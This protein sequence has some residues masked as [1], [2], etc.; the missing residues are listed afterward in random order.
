MST[1]S[2][3]SM[4]TGV[5]LAS[6]NLGNKVSNGNEGLLC[7]LERSSLVPH[8]QNRRVEEVVCPGT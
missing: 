5:R 4:W 8:V 6:C 3:W 7:A 1:L 2:V